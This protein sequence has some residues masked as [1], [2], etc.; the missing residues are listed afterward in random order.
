MK[1]LLYGYANLLTG[2][3]GLL[4]GYKIFSREKLCLVLK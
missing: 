3:K 4:Y 1:G 2:F